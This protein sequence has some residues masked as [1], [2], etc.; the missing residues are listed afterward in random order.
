MAHCIIAIGANLGARCRAINA[1]L[2]A[3]AALPTTVLKASSFV[4]ETQPWPAGS[5]DPPYLNAACAI[6]TSLSCYDLLG[7][8]QA[9]ETALGRRREGRQQWAPRE[10]D[11]DIIAFG[12]TVLREEKLTIPHPRA[13]L[14]GFVLR[15]WADIEPHAVLPSTRTRI[16]D[17]LERL[18]QK[19]GNPVRVLPVG[20][21]RVLRLGT[22]TFVMGI[23]NVTPD[24]FSDGGHCFDSVE[25]AVKH[26]LQL[27]AD[28]ADIVDIGGQSTRPGADLISADEECNRIVPVIV[29]LRRRSPTAVISV[30]TFHADVA[31]KAVSA[32]AHIINDVSGGRA[33]PNMFTTVAELAV[34]YV[35]MHSRGDSQTMSAMCVYHD[36]VADVHNELDSRIRAA[37]D[38]GVFQ[39][40][41]IADPGVG[42]AKRTRQNVELLRAGPA[43][44]TWPSVIG[45]SRKAFLGEITGR[46]A[47]DRDWATAATLAAAI[48]SGFDVVRVHNVAAASDVCRVSDSI[49]R[50]DHGRAASTYSQIQRESAP[51]L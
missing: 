1:A 22:R 39:H 5:T 2:K 51:A 6:E 40:N 42:F 33:D 13:H 34:P 48:A 18:P 47:P 4:Y 45:T 28:G 46:S 30:D 19:E 44:R 12:D 16:L 43:G 32:G 20:D 26:A 3:I 49:W 11:L 15:P 38:T 7:R 27:I 25:S 17:L 29:E 23:V 9:I 41:V 14:R 50:D 24:S 10:I 21:D 36:V 37:L 35:C 8:L 31:R